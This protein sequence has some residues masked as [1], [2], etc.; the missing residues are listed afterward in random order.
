MRHAVSSRDSRGYSS[1]EREGANRRNA[2]EREGANNAGKRAG[3]V[4]A[5]SIPGPPAQARHP[6]PSFGRTRN[7]YPF[8]ARD[9]TR[10]VYVLFCRERGDACRALTLF[11]AQTLFCR[12][13]FPL[14]LRDASIFKTTRRRGTLRERP[15]RSPA[16]SSIACARE[17]L[18]RQVCERERERKKSG[19]SP[20][21]LQPA[22]AKESASRRTVALTRP[23]L[24]KF[25]QQSPCKFAKRI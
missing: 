1:S 6:K 17:K 7:L 19:G 16:V 13:W 9:A 24:G 10:Y 23:F 25:G 8:P 14:F 18:G 3:V 20:L 12:A 4:S 15:G 22:R 5:Q 21:S 11:R 2:R